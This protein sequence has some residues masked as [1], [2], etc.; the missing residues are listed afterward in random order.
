MADNTVV[1]SHMVQDPTMS[2]QEAAQMMVILNQLGPVVCDAARKPMDQ[3]RPVP[4]IDYKKFA[5][6]QAEQLAWLDPQKFSASDISETKAPTLAGVAM[7]VEVL[8]KKMD[9]LLS[10]LLSFFKAG[11]K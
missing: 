6:M 3:A 1:P 7:D 4:Q 11:G 10:G 5:A 8:S 2:G 9:L